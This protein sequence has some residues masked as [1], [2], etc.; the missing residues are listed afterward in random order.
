MD[1]T[2]A[3]GDIHGDLEH[4]ERLLAKL[5]PLDAQDTVVFL[6][7][8]VDRGPSSRQ[9]IARIDAFREAF[10]GRCVTLRGNHEDA[11]LD[12]LQ[13]PNPGFLLPQGNGCYDTLRSYVDTSNMS[14][15]QM[16][17][18]L[19]Q[20]NTWFPEELHEWMK[21][22]PTWYEDQHA[23]YVHAGLEGE[24]EVWLSPELSK[25]RTLMWMRE[26]DFWVGYHG[27]RLVFGHTLTSE[28]PLDHLTWFQKIFDDKADVWF[29]GEHL[30]GL[31]T[32]CG[33]GGFL[34]AVELPSRTVYESR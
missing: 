19:L 8:Y 17:A 16:A 11:W 12:S 29:R 13:R 28:L 31:D 34:S 6:G 14:D 1:R 10:A 2:I 27:K 3:I 32:G 33:K 4:L 18:M 20:P 9:V 22:L 7:D 24:G 25:T 15:A 30:I 26:P 21:R 23:I 5:P